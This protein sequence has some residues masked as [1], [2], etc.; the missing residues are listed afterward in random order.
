[1]KMSD[2]GTWQRGDTVT[3]VTDDG[4]YLMGKVTS[5]KTKR[6]YSVIPNGTLGIID[7]VEER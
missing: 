4:R 6:V 5:V 1:M 7:V 2:Y 3:Y